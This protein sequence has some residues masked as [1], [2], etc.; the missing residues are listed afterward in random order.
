MMTTM[1]AFLLGIL[2][3]LLMVPGAP[4]QAQGRDFDDDIFYEELAPYGDWFE[5][6]RWGLVWQP[7]VD[8]DW[9]PIRRGIG[10]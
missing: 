4:A 5:H 7:R 3:A 1:R 9:R 8:R 2:L 10:P 6:P